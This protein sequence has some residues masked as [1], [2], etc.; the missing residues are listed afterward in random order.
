[1]L[2]LKLS[3]VQISDTA[4]HYRKFYNSFDLVCFF[5]IFYRISI[6]AVIS[7]PFFAVWFSFPKY[8]NLIT[9]IYLDIRG[10]SFRSSLDLISL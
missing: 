7:D 4:Y 1:M 10:S 6:S 5:N 3:V 9:Y 2:T 8:L